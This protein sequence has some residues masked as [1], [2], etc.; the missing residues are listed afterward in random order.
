MKLVPVRKVRG[1]ISVPTDKSIT[2]RALIFAA[3]AEGE[4]TL[5]NLLRCLD[6]ERTKD[7]LEK[8]GTKF[9]G[10]W[11]KMKVTPGVFRTPTEPLFCGNS[12][13]TTRLMAGVIASHEIFAVLYGDDSLSRRPMAR[14]MEPLG[15]MGAKFLARE[16]N[17]LP[18]A[19]QGGRLKGIEYKS[20]VAS[21]QVKSAVIIAGLRA[22]GKTTVEEPVKSRDHTERMLKKLGAS[23]QEEG[24]RVTVWPSSIKGFTMEIP[25]DVSSASFF[26]ALGVIHP[27]AKIVVRGVGLNETRIGF[28]KTLKLMGANVEWRVE[29]EDV[30]PIGTIVAES[31]PNLRGIEVPVEMIPSMIDEVPLLALVGVFAEGET[32]VKGAEELRK[33]ESDRIRVVVE[34]F[35]RLGVTIEEFPDGFRVVGRQRIRGGVVDPEGDHRMAMMFSLAGLL[36]EE[37]VEVKDH[38]CVS[39]SFPEFYGILEKVIA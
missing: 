28:L 13:T 5:Y 27:N 11:T 26:V 34:N 38:E 20:K 29:N 22:E 39:V 16:N 31:S 3:L 32:V 19:I 4:S 30:E 24:N 23:I 8:L 9:E 10:D 2:H 36:S 7:V 14:V 25:G 12:G 1:E 18:M 17:F 35:R 37:G 33:K 15:M 6:T 21:A